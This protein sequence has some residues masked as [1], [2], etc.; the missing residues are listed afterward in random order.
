[1][2]TSVLVLTGD[3]PFADPWHDLAATGAAVAAVL[4]GAVP[5]DVATRTASG[6]VADGG[7]AADLL[8][9]NLSH[10]PGGSASSSGAAP[11]AAVLAAAVERHVGRGRPVLALH[12]SVMAFPWWPAW[13]ELLGARWVDGVSGH[14]ELAVTTVRVTPGPAGVGT[15]LA[16]VTVA[17]ERYTGLKSVPG[18]GPVE[19]HLTHEHGGA[20]HPLAWARAA[21]PGGARVVYDALGHDVRSYASPSRRALLLA[22][23]AWLVGRR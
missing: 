20:V 13:A 1:M 8:V 16:D 2:G 23:V 11:D 6:V 3:G 22:E 12:S 7:F 19:P 21:R 4:T 14:P 15:G 10:D 17:D 18:D 9:V 5:A